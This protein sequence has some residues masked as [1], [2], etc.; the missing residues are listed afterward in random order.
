LPYYGIL[1]NF[2]EF[3]SLGGREKRMTLAHPTP[4]LARDVRVKLKSSRPDH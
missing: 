3:L 4:Y 2:S 1:H